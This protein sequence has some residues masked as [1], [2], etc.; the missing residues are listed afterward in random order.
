MYVF[1]FFISQ[2]L[3]TLKSIHYTTTKRF[4]PF[5]RVINSPD[6]IKKK[7]GAR[8]ICS[9]E[10]KDESRRALCDSPSWLWKKRKQGVYIEIRLWIPFFP[11]LPCPCDSSG[12]ARWQTV[13][14]R[15]EEEDSLWNR[16]GAMADVPEAAGGS[17]TGHG[18]GEW[19]VEKKKVTGRGRKE[20]LEALEA[21]GSY[22]L[23][24]H[25]VRRGTKVYPEGLWRWPKGE[26]GIYLSLSLFFRLLFPRANCPLPVAMGL[27]AYDIDQWYRVVKVFRSNDLSEGEKHIVYIG[28]KTSVNL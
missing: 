7:Y 18:A 26:E 14:R 8:A 12:N 22:V 17:V 28:S 6:R 3:L 23:L 5:N 9:Q 19:R 27:S 4:P 16:G 13:T 21:G 11:L 1:F 25:H 24:G 20:S 2:F 10:V 15:E